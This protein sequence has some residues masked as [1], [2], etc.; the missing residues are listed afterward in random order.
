MGWSG[1]GSDWRFRARCSGL[2]TGWKK[3]KIVGRCAVAVLELVEREIQLVREGLE[4]PEW[5]GARLK[6]GPLAVWRSGSFKME[7]VELVLGLFLAKVLWTP[8]GKLMEYDE[9][10]K[11]M[12]S[13]LG[14]E[15]PN[16]RELKRDIFNRKKELTVFLKRLIVLIERE[17]DEKDG[18]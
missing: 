3:K 12:E 8:G 10:I 9:I 5:F 2:V 16:Y 4:Y 6:G 18:L 14:I 15:L 7:I 13:V 17:R 11:L 1:Y